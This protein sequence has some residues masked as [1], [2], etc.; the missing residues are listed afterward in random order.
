MSDWIH[1][2]SW[3][4]EFWYVWLFCILGMSMLGDF[5]KTN[6]HPKFSVLGKLAFGIGQLFTTLGL[7]CLL[8]W[9]GD[10]AHSFFSHF[11]G[12]GAATPWSFSTWYQSLSWLAK[13]WWYY[14][15]TEVGLLCVV[16][17]VITQNR[18][19][20]AAFIVWTY[21]SFAAFSIMIVVSIFGGAINA[22]L[23]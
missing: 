1:Y 7:L 18:E 11:L 4:K 13:L 14:G 17:W 10:W 16:A 5:F 20:V 9:L 2:M 19:A 15:I 12:S 3:I 6:L 8:W 23:N 21:L 22:F